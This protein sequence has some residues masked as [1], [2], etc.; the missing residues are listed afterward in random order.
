MQDNNQRIEYIKRKIKITK[1]S[2]NKCFK[3][4]MSNKD[5]GYLGQY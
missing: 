5:K 2:S 1:G 4:E 3:Q